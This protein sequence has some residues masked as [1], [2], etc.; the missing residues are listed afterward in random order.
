MIT[1]KYPSETIYDAVIMGSGLGGLVSA[2]ILAKAGWRVCVL[3]KNNQFGGNLQ[4]F[5]RDKHIF[6]TGVHYLGSLSEG[7]NLHTYFSYLGIIDTLRLLPMDTHYDLITFQDDDNS[8]PHAQGYENFV[9]AL[10]PF[11]P[12]EEAT[13]RTYIEEIQKTCALFPRYTL[14]KNEKQY[15]EIDLSQSVADFFRH[16][17]PNEKL[18]AVLCGSNFLYGSNAEKTPFYIH[19]LTVNSYI[20]SAYKCIRGGSQITKALQKELKKYGVKLH[21]HTHITE[22][23]Y[24]SQKEIH[25]VRSHEGREFSARVF[26]SNIDIQQTLKIVGENHFNKA[27]VKRIQALQPTTSCFSLH[28]ILHPKTLEY[29]NHNI[30]HFPSAHHVFSAQRDTGETWGNFYMLTATRDEANPQYAESLTLL[31]YNDYEEFEPWKETYNTVVKH[32]ERGNAY[33]ELKREKTEKLLDAL[34]KKIPNIR[35]CIKNYEASTPLTYRDYIGASNGAL[36]GYEK[37]SQNLHASMISPKTKIPN[38]F[39]TGQTV[40]L[41]GILG[42]TIGAFVTCGEILGTQYIDEVLQ[43]FIPPSST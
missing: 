21:K 26:I 41:H 35:Q 27:Y 25:A 3:E 31:C 6:D 9:D 10:L 37:D 17:S 8:Y 28:L 38:L 39:L 14:Q 7:Q 22:A 1:E 2:L 43:P 40:N 36:Y 20:Q 5:V 29:F 42:V 32:S 12:K 4:T 34:E 23:L 11:F 24:N 33:Q 18:N 16:L 15:T 13:L 19:A 30:Y